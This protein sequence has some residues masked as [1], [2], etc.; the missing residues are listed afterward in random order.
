MVLEREFY[1]RDTL[2]VAR[3]LLGRTI[4]HETSE[5]ATAG[6][7]VETEAYKGPED[8]ASHAYANLR[9]GRTEV[10]FGP[11]GHAYVYLIYGMYYC[12]NVA[13]G[14]VP[15]KP[16]AILVRALE[17]VTGLKIMA[18]R[19][20]DV[21]DD[22]RPNLTNGPGKL[23]MAMGISTRQNGADL[24]A[25]PLHIDAGV[26]MDKA[27]IAQTARINVDYAE[28]WRYLRWRFLIHDS[29]FVSTR[30]QIS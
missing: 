12:L 10:Q 23:C 28:E 19:R 9:T 13:S 3:D 27:C 21:S 5:G 24:C 25:S 1:E 18:R 22:R 20:I 2:T 16:E 30:Q 29:A 26:P 11:K 7:I 15:G 17:P 4:V 14:E 6:I 8:K